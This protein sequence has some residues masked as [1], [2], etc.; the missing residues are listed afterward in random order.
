MYSCQP[1]T[2][3]NVT[4]WLRGKAAKGSPKNTNQFLQRQPFAAVLQ[5]R[6]S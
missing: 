3:S 4:G 5:N 6:C 1:I 2:A